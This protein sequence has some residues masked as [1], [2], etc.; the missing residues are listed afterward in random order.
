[1]KRAFVDIVIPFRKLFSEKQ[2]YPD[3][4]KRI[5]FSIIL[6]L[7]FVFTISDGAAQ[8]RFEKADS[9]ARSLVVTDVASLHEKLTRQL[10]DTIDLLRAFYTWIAENI[11]Y[12][13]AEAGKEI[14]N[15]V[16]QSA[17]R[18][19]KSRKAICHGYSSLFEELCSLSEIPCYLVSG[20]TKFDGVLNKTGHT[21]N[22]VY[23]NGKWKPVDVTWG[24]GV[25][26]DGRK[27]VRSFTDKY[28]L[29]EANEFL[30]EHYPFDPMWQLINHPVS[31]KEYSKRKSSGEAAKSAFFNF[32]DTIQN[33]VAFDST[34]QFYQSALRMNRFNSGDRIIEEQFS[35]SC[36]D[37]GN[38]L[39]AKANAI[40]EQLY[41]D[42]KSRAPQL[43]SASA[44]Q[45]MKTSLDSVLKYYNQASEFYRQAKLSEP[46]QQQVVKSNMQSLNYNTGMVRK[47]IDK[48]SE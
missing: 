20:Y 40:L 38:Q 25:V 22:I 48:L 4:K 9:I 11:R 8:Q 37:K 10:P 6:F 29:T 24:A 5:P 15:P 44:R 30:E 35:I 32:N 41:P 2:R 3:M 23:V 19:M 34:E 39:F 42:K 13:I 43:L 21:W 47:E 12:D 17:E 28:F 45:Q 7:L 46:S 33:W 1:L 26:V 14:K 36:F 27:Y 16:H 18:V 31:L